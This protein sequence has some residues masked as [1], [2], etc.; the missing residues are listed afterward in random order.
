METEGQKSNDI[1]VDEAKELLLKSISKLKEK[2]FTYKEYFIQNKVQL[3]FEYVENQSQSKCSVF[4][5]DE[6]IKIKL[7][8]TSVREG[9]KECMAQ[10]IFDS[11]IDWPVRPMRS[12]IFG[13]MVPL[14]GFTLFFTISGIA[15]FYANFLAIYLSPIF[16]L[17]YS[18]ITMLYVQK[19]DGRDMQDVFGDIKMKMTGIPL[20]SDDEIEGYAKQKSRIPLWKKIPYLALPIFGV[21]FLTWFALNPPSLEGV[22]IGDL[23]WSPV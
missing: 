13:L 1:S 17:V 19:I 4:Y 23:L 8:S 6:T 22:I 5:G 21:L 7:K 20:F 18:V 15:I 9:V 3:K 2:E 16:F 14:A 11:A 12:L 10:I